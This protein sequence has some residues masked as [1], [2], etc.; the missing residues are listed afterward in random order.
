MSTKDRDG[1]HLRQLQ[2]G[3]NRWLSC[4]PRIAPKA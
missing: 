2:Q 3:S 4:C 1:E